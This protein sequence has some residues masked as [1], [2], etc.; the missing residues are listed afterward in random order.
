[1]EKN[2]RHQD[3]ENRT[4]RYSSSLPFESIVDTI[5]VKPLAGASSHVTHGDFPIPDLRDYER[6]PSSSPLFQSA[7]PPTPEPS[8]IPNWLVVLAAIAALVAL[9]YIGLQVRALTRLLANPRQQSPASTALPGTSDVPA[10][11]PWLGISDIGPLPVTSPNQVLSVILQNYGSTPALDVRLNGTLEVDGLPAA[12][13][14][15][16]TERHLGDV[17]PGAVSKTLFALPIPQGSVAPIYRGQLQSQ[18][19][20]TITYKDVADHTHSTQ[21]CY[22]VRLSTHTMEACGERNAIN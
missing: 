20:L 15:N 16:A 12:G 9:F 21:A 4:E 14:T 10:A 22:L 13:K 7:V 8:R 19:R 6:E 17:F 1:M 3:P 2:I 18:V 11:R 5:S